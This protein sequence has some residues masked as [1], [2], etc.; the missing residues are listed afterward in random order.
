[1]INSFPNGKQE[2]SGDY[3]YK[4]GSPNVAGVL[5]DTDIT[6]IVG[7]T[8][9]FSKVKP[10]HRIRIY[11]ANTIYVRL[12]SVTNDIITITSTTPYIQEKD[13]VSKIFISTGGAGV[14]VT[15]IL[16]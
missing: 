10:A 9:L 14:A 8:N 2:Y 16:K 5:A 13:E 3:E 6:E 4:T 7:F 15:V 1:M 12:N 11:A